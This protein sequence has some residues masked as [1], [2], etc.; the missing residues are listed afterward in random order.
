M[1]IE[2]TENRHRTFIKECDGADT[3]I[4]MVHGFLGSPIQF[5]PMAQLLRDQGYTAM[6]VLLPGH[7][8]SPRDFARA[9]K[10]AWIQAVEEAATSLRKRYRH[11]ILLGHSLG[12]LLTLNEAITNGADGMVLLAVP[13]RLRASYRS[14]PLSC[15]T[16]W[17]D[18]GKDDELARF[19]R[20][21]YSISKGPLRHH[22]LWAPRA[23]DLLRLIHRTRKSLDRAYL[24]VLIF[25]SKADLTVAAKSAKILEKG[26]QNCTSEVVMLE[27]SGHSYWQPDE[28]GQMYER[29]SRFINRV[30][31]G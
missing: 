23:I 29:I 22:I 16:L 11:I 9:S 7:G 3:A 14:I 24:P 8:G 30:C 25:Q 31:N 28:A 4:L 5:E 6:A 10:T 20:T 1:G 27:K 17:G 13:M 2:A 26:L 15:R 21:V 19:G 12:G 18:P